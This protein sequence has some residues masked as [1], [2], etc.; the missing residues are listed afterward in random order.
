[1][2]DRILSNGLAGFEELS[3]DVV[4]LIEITGVVKWFDVAKGF[5]FTGYTLREVSISS[6]DQGGGQPYPR[7]MAMQ[8]KA[9]M[10]DAPVAVEAGKSTVNVTVS[11]AIQ[12][13]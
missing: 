8:A 11:G 9:S 2:A 1:M 13:R 5:G 7:A 3:G 4:D 12:L 6:A 10:A